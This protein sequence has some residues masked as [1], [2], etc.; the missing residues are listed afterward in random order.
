[1]GLVRRFW[2][3]DRRAPHT[4]WMSAIGVGL[5]WRAVQWVIEVPHAAALSVGIPI[6]TVAAA[7]FVSWLVLYERD[8][9]RG[10]RARRAERAR[11]AMSA[12]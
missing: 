1:M 11:R 6:S 2:A 9:V 4:V 12:D 7:S 8:A 10:R 5:V 3:L